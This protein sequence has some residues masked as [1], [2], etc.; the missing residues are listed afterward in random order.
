MV[1]AGRAEGQ[2]QGRQEARS[3]G[4]REARRRPGLIFSK[5]VA[6]SLRGPCAPVFLGGAHG[7]G[8]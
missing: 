6:S 5:V 2:R 7:L 3:P 1:P 4:Q 8:S